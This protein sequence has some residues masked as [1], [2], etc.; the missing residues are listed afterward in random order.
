MWLDSIHHYC[1]T[2]Y[3]IIR[4]SV[5]VNR[6]NDSIIYWPFIGNTLVYKFFSENKINTFMYLSENQKLCRACIVHLIYAGIKRTKAAHQSVLSQ[7][8]YLLCSSIHVGWLAGSSNAYTNVNDDPV[9]YFK[10]NFCL[11]RDNCLF[12]KNSKTYKFHTTC[13]YF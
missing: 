12:W 6:T 5:L 3:L 9:Q 8:F 7:M 4:I 13:T 10:I 1:V 2:K 11:N